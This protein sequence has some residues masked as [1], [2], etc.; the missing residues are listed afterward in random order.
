MPLGGGSLKRG[1]YFACES[2]GHKG[3]LCQPAS[4]GAPHDSRLPVF[5]RVF[6]GGFPPHRPGW[7]CVTNG[8]VH[9]CWNLPPGTRTGKSLRP[10]LSLSLTTHHAGSPLP[11]CEHEVI[12][13]KG[14]CGEELRPL[15]AARTAPVPQSAVKCPMTAVKHPRTPSH[16]ADGA[17]TTQGGRSAPQCPEDPARQ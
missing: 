1:V 9:R 8:M 7:T 5:T 16:H 11:C 2:S 14:L 3:G 4:T 6:G 17:R 13:R 15:L 12:S 10:P